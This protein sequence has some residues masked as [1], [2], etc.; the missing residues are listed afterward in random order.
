MVLAHRQPEAQADGDE[1]GKCDRIGHARGIGG[2]R[3]PTDRVDSVIVLAVVVI[4]VFT[5]VLIVVAAV[6]VAA[7]VVIASR[8]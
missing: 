7:V 1:T 8:G 3:S 5:T 2:C 4:V 6:V